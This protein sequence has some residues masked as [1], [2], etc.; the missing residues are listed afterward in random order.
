MELT[1]HDYETDK[2]W[3]GLVAGCV[4]G[5]LMWLFTFMLAYAIVA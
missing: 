4:I 1:E 5:G 3:K 2:F